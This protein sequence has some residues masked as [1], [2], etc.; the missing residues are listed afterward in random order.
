MKI[1]G[2]D[3]STF[4]F[5]RNEESLLP[6]SFLNVNRRD[7]LPYNIGIKILLLLRYLRE[8]D[9]SY[10]DALRRIICYRYTCL[11]SE[12]KLETSGECLLFI[13]FV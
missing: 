6:T 9:S 8:K 13:N 12:I 11:S 4:P 7:T 10:C 1:E 2:I 3:L 5:V